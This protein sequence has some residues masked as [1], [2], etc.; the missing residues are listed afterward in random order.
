VL[1]QVT[2]VLILET[3]EPREAA[4]TLEKGDEIP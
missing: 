1:L 3:E 2:L 4:M